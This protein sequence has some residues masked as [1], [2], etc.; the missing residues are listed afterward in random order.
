MIQNLPVSTSITGT[1]QHKLLIS[2]K[3]GRLLQVGSEGTLSVILDMQN[4]V[5]DFEDRGLTAARVR[6]GTAD[7]Y[8]AYSG[9]TSPE[10]SGQVATL[11]IAKYN[12]TSHVLT[13]ITTNA[14]SEVFGSHSTADIVFF[15]GGAYA[16]FGDGHDS[17]NLIDG[18]T[19]VYGPTFNGKIINL[20]TLQPYAIGFRNPWRMAVIDGS[21]YTT[22]VGFGAYE[23]VDRVVAGG[24]YGWPCFEGPAGPEPSLSTECNG[25]G[26]FILPFVSYGHDIGNAATGIVSY[27]GEILIADFGQNWI[28]DTSL[29]PRVQTTGGIVDMQVINNCLYAVSIDNNETSSSILTTCN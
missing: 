8:L 3:D 20:D 19:A 21:I 14:I 15:D 24:N 18:F 11:H 5:N 9:E 10:D 6:P 2:T 23:E 17:N 1:D 12:L 28:R 4:S 13:T 22:D 27:R 26:P 16:S 7:V 25:K 29:T